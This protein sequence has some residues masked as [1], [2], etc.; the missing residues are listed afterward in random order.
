MQTYKTGSVRA[1]RGAPRIWIEGRF[2]E[3][4]GFCAGARY[5]AVKRRDH[6]VLRLSPKGDRIVSYKEVDGRKK[7]IIDLNG[8]WLLEVFRGGSP[9][10]MI[11]QRGSI[12]IA[13]PA[14]EKRRE[15]RLT[16]LLRKL[17]GGKPLAV[18]ALAAGA[19][20]L[21]HAIKA[22][23]AAGGIRS[24][25]AVV[26]EIR[27]ELVEHAAAHNEAFDAQTLALMGPL[28]E[29]AFDQRVMA[30][31]P[32]VDIVI[33]GLPC[34][35]ASVAGRAKRKLSCAEE[36]PLVGHLVASALAVIVW[37]NPSVLIL[38]NV[39]TYANSASAAILRGQLRDLG[40]EVHEREFLATEWGDLERRKRWCLVAVTR[41][42]EFDLQALQ[43]PA[44]EPR[45]LASILEP[46][47][48]VADR[49][50][51]MQSL[52]EKEARDQAAGRNFLMQIFNG[53]ESH[54]N[55]LTK[56]IS[57]GRSTDPKIQH[58][59]DPELLRNPT[60]R[61][62]ARAKGVPEHL[63]AG[64]CESTA[65]EVLGQGVCY[66]P[67]KSLGEY[68][69]RTLQRFL[70]CSQ[71]LTPAPLAASMLQGVG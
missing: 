31:I 12:V 41:G 48:A 55:T 9:L 70:E 26:N 64:L 33:A 16:R 39:P 5:E 13:P 40:Y 35:G 67:F 62:H 59:E 8:L 19:G 50:S 54:I 47:E 18:G 66:S 69:A 29:I 10:R 61:E 6:L 25:L 11:M 68:L 51:T 32:K 7:P 37:L 28:Q 1:N 4:A 21:D 2:P 27:E 42:I 23:L 60:H 17:L 53:E 63:I 49:F 20:I 57:K 44:F 24:H 46:L 36:H 22:G 30:R 38:E 3:R 52:K 14:S 43:P 71:G 45:Q 56:G 65:H 15:A 34:S 58:P